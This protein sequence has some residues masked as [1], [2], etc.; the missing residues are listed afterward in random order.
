VSPELCDGFDPDEPAPTSLIDWD[1]FWS[2]DAAAE[3]WILEPIVAAGRQ[4]AIYST[5]KTGKSLLALD[6][7]AAGATGRSVL[8]FAPR[9]PISV[10]YVDLEMTKADLRERLVDLGYGPGDD[11]SRLNYYQLPAWPALDGELGGE[12]LRS[13]AVEHGA[14]LVVID[15]MARAVS[16]RENDADTYRDFFR[17]TGRHLKADGVAL[18]RLD[19][20]GKGDGKGQRGSS[21]KDDDLDVVFRLTQLDVKTFKLTRTRNRIPW[22]PA[23]VTIVREESPIL[24]HVRAS[25]FVPAGTREA[26]LALDELEVPTDASADTALATL[27]RAGKGVR[28]SSVLA[29]QK[30]RRGDQR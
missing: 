14:R 17:H 26:I 29:A 22:V 6:I 12:I 2:S 11:L 8:G 18:L 21:A 30:A 4:T 7:A 1:A 20:E 25:D 27:R 10:V 13:T 19:H 5:A 23:D 16:G 15:T 24:R 9:E 3:D 28:K